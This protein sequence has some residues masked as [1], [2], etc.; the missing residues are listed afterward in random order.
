MADL[1]GVDGGL[2]ELA[3]F[4]G[5]GGGILGGKLLG[6][7][8]VCAVE[9]EPYAA[10]VL[11][12]RQNDRLLPPFPIWD[13]IR[14][15]D[16]FPWKGIVDIVSGGFPCQAYSTAAS[17]KNVADDFWPEMRRVV[18]DV[19]PWNVFAE[20]VSRIAIE[21]AAQ[22]LEE[23]GYSAQCLTLSAAD[24]G[25]DHVRKRHW[26]FAYP[27]GH[28]KLRQPIHAKVEVLPKFCP[29]VWESYPNESR[30]DDGVAARVD[31]LKAIGNGQ[32]PAV[33]AT[34]FKILSES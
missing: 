12:A 20:N 6:W 26:L 33:A 1:T 9:W 4:A 28:S 23:M 21:Q 29:G 2:R 25:S 31:R 27:D 7:R 15:F 8:T 24:M 16:G 10:S 34:A 3:L 30:M 22:D 17:G 32:V 13:D 18:A 11:L 5:A 14:T 19:A